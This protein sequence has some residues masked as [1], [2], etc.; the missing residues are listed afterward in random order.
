MWLHKRRNFH[1]KQKS[2]HPNPKINC[3]FLKKKSLPRGRSK[4][5]WPQWGFPS[6]FRVWAPFLPFL[7]FECLNFSKYFIWENS[8]QSHI[9]KIHSKIQNYSW[10]GQAFPLAPSL[11][12]GMWIV[13]SALWREACYISHSSRG[14]LSNGLSLL[15][16]LHDGFLRGQWK[17]DLQQN[18]SYCIA[19]VMQRALLP[20]Y[21]S[22]GGLDTSLARGPNW[23]SMFQTS[24]N[25]PLCRTLPSPWPPA[26]GL[27]YH[28][29]LAFIT[30]KQNKQTV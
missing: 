6:P 3:H 19:D 15:L 8:N 29:T 10:G 18:L 21:P 26:S 9:R 7:C 13:L 22:P 2:S 28:I 24:V 16:I 11:I 14:A 5:R 20:E 25:A 23:P 12:G 4:I 30:S 27:E 17:S 1:P